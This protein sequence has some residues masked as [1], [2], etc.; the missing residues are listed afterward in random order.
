MKKNDRIFGSFYST[1]RENQ[2]IVVSNARL[3][4]SVSGVS[5]AFMGKVMLRWLP[6]PALVF[7]AR[8]SIS[9]LNKISKWLFTNKTFEGLY[10]V[11]ESGGL[12][13]IGLA[14]LR[15]LSIGESRI[16]ADFHVENFSSKNREDLVRAE[17]HIVNFSRMHRREPGESG[18]STINNIVLEASGWKIILFEVSGRPK[19]MQLFRAGFQITHCGILERSD[20]SDFTLLQAHSIVDALSYFLSFARRGWC[21]AGLVVGFNSAGSRYEH[22]VKPREVDRFDQEERHGGGF[23]MTEIALKGSVGGFLDLWLDSGWNLPLQTAIGW[24]LDACNGRTN[25]ASIVAGQ[26]ALELIAWIELVERKQ[27]VS[28]DGFDKLPAADRLKLL[29]HLTDVAVPIPKRANALLAFAS[30]QRPSWE[31]GPRALTEFRN[32]VIHPKRRDTVL[33]AP[34]IAKSEE[35]QLTLAYLESVFLRLFNYRGQ[36]GNFMFQTD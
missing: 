25:E 12:N 3:D 26:T 1:E 27:V 10:T 34:E 28:R 8:S 20:G 5:I 36:L 24:Y 31:D 7:E 15:S 16:N 21:F 2:P 30:R 32:S 35:E 13:R 9:R 14:R 17:F 29:L 23:T 11:Q 33:G 6:V 19:D 22:A 4:A 18:S